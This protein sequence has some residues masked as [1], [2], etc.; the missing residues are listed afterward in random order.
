MLDRLLNNRKEWNALKEE[1]EAKLAALEEAKKAKEEATQ[2][3]EGGKQGRS[4]PD[5]LT[6]TRMKNIL[7]ISCV[8]YWLWAETIWWIDR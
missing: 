3:V 6:R 8:T 5:M 4:L 7:C 1:H 2:K